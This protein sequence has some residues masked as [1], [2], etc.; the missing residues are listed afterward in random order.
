MTDLNKANRINA[1]IELSVYGPLGGEQATAASSW[2]TAKLLADAFERIERLESQTASR[3]ALAEPEP[4]GP[5]DEEVDVWADDNNFVKGHG[6]HPCGF[7][8]NDDD[9]GKIVRAAL[10]RWGNRQGFFDSSTQPR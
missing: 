2:E 4:E 6:D 3:A 5:T 1:E 9:L 10:A 8:V 7:W